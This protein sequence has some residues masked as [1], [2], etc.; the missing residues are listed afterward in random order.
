[1]TCWRL[2]E[3]EVWMHLFGSDEAPLPL[4][5]L[6]AGDTTQERMDEMEEILLPLITQG[7]CRPFMLAGFGP[8]AWDHDYAPWPLETPDGRHFGNGADELLRFAWDQFLPAVQQQFAHSG[9]TFP[10]GYSLGGLAALYFAGLNEWAGC[11]SCS[12]SLWYPGFADWLQAHAPRFPVY[13]SLGGKEKNTKD[14]LMAQVENCTRAVHDLLRPI[15]KTT[16]VH[17]PGGHFRDTAQRL[18]NAIV[19]LL[20]HQS[21]KD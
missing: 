14:P 17:E 11:G 10:V 7:K 1:M 15:T 2:G 8:V 13:L 18:A 16:F 12:G 4:V 21:R 3:K 19:W 9:E 5:W 20:S 6:M